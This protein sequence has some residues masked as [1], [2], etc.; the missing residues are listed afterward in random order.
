MMTFLKKSLSWVLTLSLFLAM[1]TCLSVLVPTSVSAAAPDGQY[2]VERVKLTFNNTGKGWSDTNSEG[3]QLYQRDDPDNAGNKYM[4]LSSPSSSGYNMELADGDNSTTAYEMVGNTSYS[5]SFKFK[6][7]EVTSSNSDININFG[8]QS[9]YS[10]SISKPYMMTYKSADYNDGEW[11]TVTYDFTTTETMEAGTYTNTSNTNICNRLY[12]VVTGASVWYIDEVI[13]L[14]YAPLPETV[15]TPEEEVKLTFNTTGKGWSD[16]YGAGDYISQVAADDGTDNKYIQLSGPTS[17]GAYNFELADGD[18]SNTA[19]EMV[20]NQYYVV[21]VKFKVVSGTSGTLNINFGTQSSY[22]TSLAKP[23]MKT[24]QLTDYN[25]GNWHTVSYE[26]TTTETM[27]GDTYMTTDNTNVCNRLYIVASTGTCFYIDEVIIQTKFSEQPAVLTERTSITFNNTNQGWSDT[28]STGTQLTQITDTEVA[29]NKYMYLLTPNGDGYNMEL[30]DGDTS[31]TAFVLQPSTTYSLTVKA[32]RVSETEGALCIHVGTQAAYSGSLDKP[33]IHTYS[34]S[35]IST[36]EWTTLPAFEF[37][38]SET[39][40][41]SSF[42]S[43]YSKNNICDRLYLVASGG[44]STGCGFYIDEVVITKVGNFEIP[45]FEDETEDNTGS[46]GTEEETEPEMYT[47]STF[48][49]EPYKT[50]V[51]KGGGSGIWYASNRWYVDSDEG[52][53]IL[54]YDF[55]Y[56]IAENA[57]STSGVRGV[58]AR[59]TNG[60]TN[61]ACAMVY[62]ANSPIKITQGKSYRISFKY[63]VLSVE[64]NS[65]VSF[66]V[67][68]GMCKS[69]WDYSYG[70]SSVADNNNSRYIIDIAIAPT[71][72]WIDAELTFTADYTANTD[73]NVLQ[74]GGCGYGEAMIDD[75]VFEEI[76]ASEVTPPNTDS[77]KYGT[78][79]TNNNLYLTELKLTDETVT[80]PS[81][82]SHKV[83]YGIKDYAFLYNRYV[84]NLTFEN[85]PVVIGN[86][87]FEY[88]KAL[89]TVTLPASITEIGKDAFFGIKTLTAVNVD[90]AN[91]A[92]V[93]VDGVLYTKDMTTLIVYPASKAGTSFTVPSTV[94]AILAGAFMNAK[95]LETVVLPEGLVSIGRRA[96]CDCSALTSINVPASVTAI[97]ASAFRGCS[98]L[99]ASGITFESEA[100]A[101]ENAFVDSSLYTVGSVS[102]DETVD[103]QDATVLERHLAGFKNSDLGRF[104]ALAADIN[105]DGLVDLLD[106]VL[107]KRHLAD[108]KGYESL[109]CDG[110][111]DYTYEAY[112]SDGTTPE[113]VINLKESNS[114]KATVDRDIEY[115]SNKEDII[116]I[117]ATGQSNGTTSVGYRHEYTYYVND[118]H[119][120]IDDITAE[121]ARPEQGTVFSGASV[122]SLSESN[123]VYFLAD[124]EKTTSCMGGYTPALGKTLYE[125]TGAKVVFVQAAVGAV[126]VHE[127]TPDPENW[128]CTCPNNGGG[129]LYKNAIANYTKSYQALKEQY[130][131]VG[132]AYIYLQGE[133]EQSDFAYESTVATVHDT[134]TYEQA[135]MAMHNGFMEDCELDIGGI[136]LPRTYAAYFT[137][138]DTSNTEKNSR[139]PTYARMAQL[140][141]A[142]DTDDLFLFSNFTDLIKKEG[143]NY[144]T[145]PTNWIHYSQIVYNKI[146]EECAESFLKSFGLKPATEFTGIT[147]YNDFGTE[148]CRFDANGNV[149]SGSNVLSFSETNS[150]G[151]LVNTQLYFRFDAGTAYTY[152]L[153]SAN[154]DTDFV[155]RY[156]YITEVSG[157]TEFKIVINPAK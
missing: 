133:H 154:T 23:Y 51:Q 115:D 78:A 150:N 143:T 83:L 89:E 29:G 99:K 24:W 138:N 44:G 56:D 82:I 156:C 38:T 8:T 151:F 130:N 92:F 22:S 93:S 66:S 128:Y 145:D 117:L 32:K 125:A 108:W 147:V 40:V 57:P 74:I 28:N 131:I 39:L 96:F 13:I 16:S 119:G 134:A 14:K 42:A 139:R 21:S 11:H 50:Y 104:E 105:G 98:A 33:K 157:Q 15:Y 86:Y 12:L 107:L 49:Y 81:I 67:M 114:K 127:W 136:V 137:G 55:E 65:Y 6:I 30:A 48:D 94:T 144:N 53:D 36:T 100:E 64:N 63:K 58:D 122:T 110:T 95:N 111:A 97:G 129:N 103:V 87:A 43:G 2:P 85:G 149:V 84:K 3:T 90:G 153:T 140:A 112:T 20:G 106:A 4:E 41:S 10:G 88:A 45:D 102:G 116:I 126:G 123:D 142:N 75:I 120:T 79:I 68:R 118:G 70:V 132:T 61:G 76:D 5:V 47:I 135:Y 31:T 34:G 113:V 152:D 80:I 155:D 25:D 46:G 101:G 17:T 73:F 1:F 148:V 72:G 91:T 37:T 77:S 109:P 141:A 18:S 27:T 146:G 60:D 52:Y 121:T 124:P 35:S 26:F 69:G 62:A 59:G 19:Y 54:H 7:A 9:A 71:D